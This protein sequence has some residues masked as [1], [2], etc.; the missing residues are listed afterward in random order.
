MVAAWG[1]HD[2]P[3]RPALAAKVAAAVN[4]VGAP[5]GSN[6][7]SGHLLSQAIYVC[8]A[9]CGQEIR[10]LREAGQRKGESPA[11]M[12]IARPHRRPRRPLGPTILL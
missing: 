1:G 12:G 2:A 10:G 9:G 6:W 4:L 8:A 5:K 3:R 7:G 11:G